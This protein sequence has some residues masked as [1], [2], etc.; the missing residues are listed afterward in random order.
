MVNCTD[1]TDEVECR[2]HGVCACEWGN[3][4]CLF[5]LSLPHDELK[6]NKHR[7]NKKSRTNKHKYKKRKSSRVSK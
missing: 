5:S 2:K 1:I 7:T 4:K 6:C 3:G